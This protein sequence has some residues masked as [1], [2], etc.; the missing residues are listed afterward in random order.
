MVSVA[1]AFNLPTI[2]LITP[3]CTAITNNPTSA[4]NIFQNVE[5]G[6]ANENLGQKFPLSLAYISENSGLLLSGGTSCEIFFA[7]LQTAFQTDLQN[8]KQSIVNA[9]QQFMQI[10]TNLIG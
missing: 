4:S 1:G 9:K 7:G 5:K 10:I 8:D 6:F 2:D 3:I